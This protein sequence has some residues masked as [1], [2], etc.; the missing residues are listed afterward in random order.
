MVSPELPRTK[1]KPIELSVLL[2]TLFNMAYVGGY[3]S[4]LLIKHLPE[5]V[6]GLAKTGWEKLRKKPTKPEF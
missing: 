2:Y 3:A 5:I 6:K 1:E 4:Y